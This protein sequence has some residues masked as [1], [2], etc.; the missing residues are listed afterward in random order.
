MRIKLSILLLG[1][2]FLTGCN[3]SYSDVPTPTPLGAQP[4]ILFPTVTAP[5]PAVPTSV[6]T[7]T[8]TPIAPVVA[9][10][11]TDLQAVALIDSLK[12]AIINN[13]GPLLSSLVSPNGMEVRYF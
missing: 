9:N 8:A 2:L 10:V 5:P 13:D 11:C 7:P 1:L 6:F 3:I 12:R 4:V